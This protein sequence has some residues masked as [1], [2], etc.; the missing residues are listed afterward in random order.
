MKRFWQFTDQ[1]TDLIK[2]GNFSVQVL[3]RFLPLSWLTDSLSPQTKA[4]M[5][6]CPTFL[7]AFH[8]HAS[9]KL[10]LTRA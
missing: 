6:T 8:L 7:T 1:L 4:Q 2:V 5:P 10:G 9:S 3:V